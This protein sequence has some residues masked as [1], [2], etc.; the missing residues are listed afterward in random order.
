MKSNENV[1]PIPNLQL[2]LFQIIIVY[3]VVLG[4]DHQ[5]VSLFPYNRDYHRLR[6][7]ANSEILEFCEWISFRNGSDFD[8]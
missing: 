5:I 6:V 2:F 7:Y 3:H 8:L 4:A 1:R